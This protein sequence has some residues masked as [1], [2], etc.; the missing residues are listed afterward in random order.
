VSTRPISGDSEIS[1]DGGGGRL[2]VPWLRVPGPRAVAGV[3][4]L[5]AERSCLRLEAL[6]NWIVIQTR[7]ISATGTASS[8]YRLSGFDSNGATIY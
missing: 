8:L 1:T 6:M 2:P 3:E 5:Q 4:R 7:S